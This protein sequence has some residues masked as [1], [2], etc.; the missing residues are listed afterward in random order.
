MNSVRSNSISVKY[1]RFTLSSCE[2][3][4]IRK[5]DFVVKTQFLS[6]IS[7]FHLFVRVIFDF[8]A[9]HFNI[10]ERDFIR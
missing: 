6:V 2:D 8:D 5:F 7:I 9:K 4:D 1:Q 3:I 10:Y